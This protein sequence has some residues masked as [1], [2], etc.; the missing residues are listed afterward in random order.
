MLNYCSKNIFFFEILYH[1]CSV[2]IQKLIKIKKIDLKEWSY[3][4]S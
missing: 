2:V 1:V 4:N 3:I